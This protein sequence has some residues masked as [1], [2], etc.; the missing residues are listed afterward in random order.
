M[1]FDT[2]ESGSAVDDYFE[3]IERH[4]GLRRGGP[5]MLSPRDWQLLAKWQDGGLPLP[6]VLRGINRAFDLFEAGGPRSDRINSLSYCRQH[7]E[8]VWQEH[9]ELQSSEGSGA[10]AGGL[11]A[12]GDHLDAVAARVR[13]TAATLDGAAATTLAVVVDELGRLAVMARQQGADVRALDAAASALEARAAT[14]VEG[15]DAAA[16]LPRF[17]PW[18]A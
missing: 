8:E 13:I 4:F 11:S 17:S 5:L 2:P 10:V 15:L 14:A 16:D 6:V 9:R 18:A 1:T 12:A 3:R 7:V